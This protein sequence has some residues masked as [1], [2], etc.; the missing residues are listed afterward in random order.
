[1]AI[2]EEFKQELKRRLNIADIIGE[3]V[4]LK[5]SGRGL[6]GKCPFHGDST[7]SFSVSPELGVYH[8]FGCNASGDIVG[9]V[10]QMEHLDYIDAIRWLAQKAGLTV[11]ENDT[12]TASAK[13]RQRIFEAN[14]E[15]AHFYV[16]QLYTPEGQ[17][18]LS[19]LKKRRLSSATITH[20][21]LGYSPKSRFALVSHL[22]S[23][24]FSGTE[25]IQANLANL[26]Q[27]G[28]PYDRF[29]DRVMFPIIDLQRRVIGFG[30]R[31]MSD[32]K[33]KYLNTSETPVFNKSQNLYALQFAKNEAHGQLI[34]VEGY[35]DVIALHQA[36]FQNAVAT[37]GT[38][39]TQEQALIIKRYCDE[40]VICYDADE[41]GQKATARAIGILRPTGLNIRILTVPNGKDPD[42]FIKSHGEQGAARF[43]MLLNKSGNDVDYRLNR[44]RARYQ[45]DIT[46]QRVDFL[47]EACKLL[48]T[49]DNSIEK[50][51]YIAKLSE[52]LSIDK[53]ALKQQTEKY[54]R[55]NNRRTARQE[56]QEI[57]RTLSLTR[58]N[59]G[60]AASCNL[61]AASTEEALIALLIAHP[62]IAAGLFP[63][64]SPEL[65]STLFYRKVY[66][67]L[68]HRAA[69]GYDFSITDISDSF[70]EDEVSRIARILAVHPRE[71]D[72]RAAAKDYIEIL[73]EEAERL[74][75]E[76]IAAADNDTLLEQ[77]RRLRNKKQ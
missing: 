75:P 71:E 54:T 6:M 60:N 33:P 30:G 31:I 48:A 63:T 65:F 10:R 53:A 68:R 5:K 55:I 57:R 29:S 15:A 51:I 39:L 73:H 13:L 40:V 34:L 11:P 2:S 47:T 59:T 23:K 66:E 76:Q 35:M 19:Y 41:A 9:F 7:P 61:R 36:G 74:T 12:D 22:K 70:S 32:I 49:L 14:R 50:D 58:E 64:L 44:L 20:F 26:S 1:M 62:D 16:R 45:L 28:N 4:T 56:Q 43:R 46:Q 17:E 21:G 18:A 77:V 37:L 52:E 72:P 25:M 69:Q 3:Y 67:T 8:C 38:A 27:K 42:E 24:G